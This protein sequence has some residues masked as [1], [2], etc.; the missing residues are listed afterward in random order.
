V[1]VGS[2]EEVRYQLHLASRLGYITAD[3]HRELAR[4]FENVKMMLTKLSAS[5]RRRATGTR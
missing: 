3:S 2:C 1:A 4:E 5:V